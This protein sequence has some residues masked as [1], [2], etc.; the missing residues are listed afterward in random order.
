M[1]RA[2]IGLL[3][4]LLMP[5]LGY[6]AWGNGDGACTTQSKSAGTSL[7]CTVSTANFDAGNVA[8]VWFGGDNTDTVDGSHGLVSAVAD[9][10]SNTWKLI[11]CYTNA[12]GSSGAGATTCLAY[13]VLTTTLVS[14]VDTITAT[15]SSITARAMV[16]KEFTKGGSSTVFAHSGPN[17]PYVLAND[18]ADPGSITMT[19]IPNMEHLF[20][21]A[22]ALERA[23]GGTWTVSASF[24]TSG[25]NGTSGSTADTNIEICGEYR[26]VS[27]TSQAS[28]PTGTA[29]D[30]ANL[31][32]VFTEATMPA[33]FVQ[34][35]HNGAGSPG[36]TTDCQF[37]A[38]AT[39]GNLIACYATDDSTTDTVTLA[40]TQSNTYTVQS[41]YYTDATNTERAVG[42]YAKNITGG[43]VKVTA[44]FSAST[45][46]RGLACHEIS[47]MDTVDPTDGY[48]G[49]SQQNP[50]TGTDAVT[51]TTTA[52]AGA[53]GYLFGATYEGSAGCIT[54]TA[55]TNWTNVHSAGC[56]YPYTI[57]R[58]SAGA[59]S[60]A[61]TYTAASGTAD[62]TTIIQA[63][64]PAIAGGILIQGG[65]R[66][67][68]H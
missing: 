13:S 55:G 7:A 8:F 62:Y 34:E 27:S 12:Q 64:K 15:H 21:R 43:L 16:T 30:N 35:C 38:Y 2:L 56:Q 25:C 46:H 36:T 14:G 28:D 68:L 57:A 17:S 23:S 49:Q 48:V 4:S 67:G 22:S 29:V 6:A 10:Q 26:I 5:A 39:A 66:G 63:F 41:T 24:T 65:Y 32:I 37:G 33:G 20:I 61:A 47:G 3:F 11:Q 59:G 31:A 51:S 54:V 1:T 19:D 45:N 50:G 9:S 42:A 52:T 44:T 58:A 40:D 18:A 53:T 60:Y